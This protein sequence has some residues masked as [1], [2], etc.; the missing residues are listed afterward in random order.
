MNKEHWCHVQFEL[1]SSVSKAGLSGH[2][3]EGGTVQLSKKNSLLIISFNI[4]ERVSY[5]TINWDHN[6][7]CKA[8][9]WHLRS[10][11]IVIRNL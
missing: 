6:P 8:K 7:A 4:Q 2:I 10:E 3:A 9:S 11:L 5:I 1:L